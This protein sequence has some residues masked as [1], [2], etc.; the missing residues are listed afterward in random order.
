MCFPCQSETHRGSDYIARIYPEPTSVSQQVKGFI[1]D[2]DFLQDES[3]LI[4]LL[5]K[6]RQAIALNG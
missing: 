6:R 4:R 1:K 5:E 3:D 2:T